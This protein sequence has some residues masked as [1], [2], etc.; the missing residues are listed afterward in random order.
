MTRDKKQEKISGRTFV[1]D[2]AIIW[3][4]DEGLISQIPIK[5]IRI[6]GEYTT[7]EG[8]FKDDW[9]FVFVLDSDDI[10]QVSA[11]ATGTEEMLRQV[12]Q[13]ITTEL[14]EQL[15]NSTNWKSNVLWPAIFRGQEL[16][17]LTEKQPKGTWERI[18]SEIGL[19]DDKEIEL[20]DSL[21]KYLGRSASA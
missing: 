6:I 8:P 7:N 21:K 14:T 19:I 11:Y 9:F 18:K 1:K 12:G 4:S 13:I 3:D 17:K 15:A 10:R 16:F 20:T 2:Q 5:E